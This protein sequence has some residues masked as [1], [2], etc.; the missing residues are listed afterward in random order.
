MSNIG[1]IGCQESAIWSIK[2]RR[3]RA[4]KIGDIGVRI[5]GHRCFTTPERL[6]F[7]SVGSV[8]KGKINCFAK[9]AHPH[10][11]NRH[12]T[13]TPKTN[14]ITP[15]MTLFQECVKMWEKVKSIVLQI[16]RARI[17]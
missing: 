6:R 17:H 7:R 5:G 11:L 13:P 1:A 8:G 10:S 16:L 12:T 9:C 3:Y 4:S 2:N 14:A 15:E